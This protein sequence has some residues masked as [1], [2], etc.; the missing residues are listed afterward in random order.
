MIGDLQDRDASGHQV[1]VVMDAGI[2]TEDNVAYL[3]K[4]GLAYLVVSRKKH[5]EFDESQSVVVKESPDCTV[6]VQK[7]PDPDTGETL[8]YCHST[9]REKKERAIG[10]LF[11]TRFE[12]ASRIRISSESIRCWISS[13]FLVI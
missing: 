7:V 13:T 11:S 10:R 9:Q 8:L 3:K 1:T 12:D 2:A 4:L 6:K 5:R